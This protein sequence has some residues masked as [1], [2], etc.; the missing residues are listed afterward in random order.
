V[1]CGTPVNISSAGLGAGGGKTSSTQ[2]AD[3]SNSTLYGVYTI[4]AFFGGSFLNIIGPR[5]ALSVSHLPHLSILALNL[6]Q[7]TD[8]SIGRC[9]WLRGVCGWTVVL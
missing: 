5:I 3:I 2:V 8:V 6:C 9:I 4:V 1:Q 7:I